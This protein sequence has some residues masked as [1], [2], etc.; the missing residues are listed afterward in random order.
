MARSRKPPALLATALWLVACSPAAV[1]TPT[2]AAPS[3]SPTT[4]S[5]ES[6]ERTPTASAT[7]S[8]EPTFT[9]QTYPVPAG[10][11]PHDVAPAADGGV[12]YTAQGSG[13]LGWLDPESGDVRE[14]NLG[15]GSAPHGVIVGPDGAPWITD[16]GRNAII[17]VDPETERVDEFPLPAAAPNANLNTAAF[18]GDGIL[19]F[20]GQSGFYGS[21]DPATGR[22]RAYNAPRGQGPYGITAT[23]DGEI[24]FSSL[25]G[26]YL[27]AVD[28]ESGDVEVIDPPT[29]GAGLRRA[30]SDSQGRIWVS[31]WFV[32]KVGRFDPATREWQEWPL[33]DA[34]AQA[35]AVFV[36]DTDA[37]WLT[38]FNAN[39]I[40]RFDP[41]SETFASFVAESQ[42]AEVRQLLGRPGELWGAE[43]AADQLVVVRT[44]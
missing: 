39:A 42:P 38:D 17:R 8:R 34:G 36:D 33:P 24:Y 37:V 30:W 11:H 22:V 25:A 32:G 18:D 41:V 9:V 21:V 27:G 4:E 44:D 19:W 26:S 15:P 29:A 23:P 16:G 20:T 10:S 12:W 3:P 40:V 6:A 5:S 31:E 35:Y 7:P 43:S 14:V 1:A 28:R 13:E 2:P